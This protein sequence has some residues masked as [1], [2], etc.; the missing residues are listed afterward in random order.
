MESME[1]DEAI[2]HSSHRPWKSLRRLPHFH[3]PDYYGH[4]SIPK[5]TPTRWGQFG[6]AKGARSS[7]QNQ[8]RIGNADMIDRSYLADWLEKRALTK[9]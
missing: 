9:V 1:N 8:S 3:R 6:R 7:R 2:S 5:T 4:D